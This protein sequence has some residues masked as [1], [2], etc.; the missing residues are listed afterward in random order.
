MT[1]IKVTGR[2]YLGAG[3]NAKNVSR[4]RRSSEDEDVA[5]TKK[6]EFA[7]GTAGKRKTGTRPEGGF[8]VTPKT[9]AHF[10]TGRDGSCDDCRSSAASLAKTHF[11]DDRLHLCARTPAHLTETRARVSLRPKNKIETLQR[12][13]LVNRLYG[14]RSR[15]K[16]YLIVESLLDCWR[17]Q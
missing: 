16:L 5:R 15:V 3:S 14:T 9:T 1:V 2:Y 12:N 6:Y 13:A 10:S 17:D 8:R 11:L 7:Q 4:M